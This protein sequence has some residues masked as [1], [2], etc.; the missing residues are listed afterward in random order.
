MGIMSVDR[1]FLPQYVGQRTHR[2]SLPAAVD[3]ASKLVNLEQVMH[4]VHSWYHNTLR[5]VPINIRCGIAFFVKAKT[6]APKMRSKE[7]AG[8][9]NK[10]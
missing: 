8:R 6:T 9:Q 4:G 7:A 1:Q 5:R 10:C 3:C 2:L